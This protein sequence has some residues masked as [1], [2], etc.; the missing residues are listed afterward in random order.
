MTGRQAPANL[1]AERSV[2]GSILINPT[3]ID[4]VLTELEA[5]DFFYPAHGAI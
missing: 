3:A 2:L 1:D 5:N 4:E